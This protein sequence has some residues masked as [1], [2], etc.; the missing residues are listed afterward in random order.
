[1]F[2][3]KYMMTAGYIYLRIHSVSLAS[4]CL[5]IL[6]GWPPNIYVHIRTQILSFCSVSS[7]HLKNGCIYFFRHSKFSQGRDLFFVY[8]RFP[9][10][11]ASG[12]QCRGVPMSGG[13]HRAGPIPV[14]KKIKDTRYKT[15]T[16][17]LEFGLR[18][19]HTRL[20]FIRSYFE[21]HVFAYFSPAWSH[22]VHA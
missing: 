5:L 12:E 7:R 21:N 22:L 4:S 19:S 1:M 20:L 6:T 11:D 17:L 2:S 10:N 16:R 15:Y 3:D 13:S 14:L 9:R 18:P 8:L